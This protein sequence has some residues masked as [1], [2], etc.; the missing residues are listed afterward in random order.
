MYLMRV[1]C[2]YVRMFI[3]FF[4]LCPATTWI[5]SFAHPLSLLYALPMWS[6][7]GPDWLSAGGRGVRLDPACPL[8]REDWLA[9]ADVGGAAS[10]ARILCAAPIDETA[11][12]TLFAHRI[13]SGAHVRFDPATGGVKATHGRHIGAIQLSEIGRAHV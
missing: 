1:F 3:I 10:G 8:A 12:E 9:V 4:C 11:I 13:E 6:G 2:R 5:Y 7:A